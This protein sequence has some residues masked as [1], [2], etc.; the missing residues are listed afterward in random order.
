M[1]SLADSP[2]PGPVVQVALRPISES[3]DYLCHFEGDLIGRRVRV[4]LGEKSHAVGV[5][6]GT[7]ETTEV[8]PQKLKEVAQ[9][10]DDMPPLPAKTLQLIHFCARYYHTSPGKVIASVLPKFF[11]RANTCR[12]AGGYRRR[13]GVGTPDGLSGMAAEVFSLLA[14]GVVLSLAQIKESVKNPSAALKRLLEGGWVESCDLPSPPSDSSPVPPP[15]LTAAQR[16]A[17]DRLSLTSGFVPHL[18]FGRTGS[19]K[20]EIYLHAVAAALAAG[21]QALVLTPEIHLTPQLEE[22]FRHRFPGGRICVLHSQLADGERAA[23]WLEA[24]TGAADVVLGTRSAVLTPMPRLGVIVVDEEHDDSYKQEGGFHYSAVH[25]AVWRAKNEG[26]PLIAGSATPSLGVYRRA[27]EGDWRLL[28]LPERISRGRSSFE[29]ITPA[30]NQYHGMSPAFLRNLSDCLGG[31]GQALVFVNRRGYAPTVTCRQCE[32]IELCPGCSLRMT[33]HRRHNRLIC[34]LCGRSAPLPRT[35]ADCGGAMVLVGAGTQRL[36]EALERLYPEV[37]QLR[38]DSD[39][40]GGRRF[41]DCRDAIVA[42]EYRLLIGTQI[43]AKG[44][45]FPNLSLIGVLNADA[46]LMSADF[47]A[48]ERLFATLSQVIGRGS[49][50]PDG[51]HVMIQTRHPNHQ[52]FSDLIADDVG[53][54]WHRLMAERRASGMPPFRWLAVLRGRGRSLPSL[55][56]FMRRARETALQLAADRVRVFDVVS[57]PV[58]RTNYWHHRQI[59]FQSSH[60]PLL[61]QF[62]TAFVAA[63]PQSRLPWSV[64][65][66]PISV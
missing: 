5:V 48:E 33:A 25:V 21:R 2:P 3:L 53:A 40:M 19:G 44:H 46:G 16:T 8:P 11:R 43:I 54:C 27:T 22:R 42:G 24:L 50:N 64:D 47:R 37:P 55:D 23:R 56:D 30:D 59:L 49:R 4:P 45:D 31:G 1:N 35:C 13:E 36:E 63:L 62:L 39:S 61:H 14:D 29:L 20:T 15:E 17:I 51:C 9:V 60:R 18:L 28:R 58:A 52:F 65:I 32:R 41:S 34:H 38:L 66:D 12:T 26:L 6:V 10:Y 7:A 57:P